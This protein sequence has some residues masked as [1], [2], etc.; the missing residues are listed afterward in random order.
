MSSSSSVGS[1]AVR[2]F[3]PPQRTHCDCG[4]LV[5]RWNSWK[6]GNLGRRFIGCPNY[7][8]SSK[9]CKFFDWVDPPLPN[10]WYKGL[11][12]Q[13]HNG[14][15]GDVVEQMEEAVV[16]VVPAQVQGVG[17]VVPG[18]SMLWF[19]LGLCFGLYFKIM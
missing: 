2:R 9:D 19:I 10:Q 1:K 18:W 14:W 11:L 17:G 13:L 8:D 16:E 12:L 15:N 6:T 7:R 4:D 3:N 5:G